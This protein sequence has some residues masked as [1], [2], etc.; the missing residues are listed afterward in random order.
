VRP[1]LA[2]RREASV[3]GAIQTENNYNKKMHSISPLVELHFLFQ[4]LQQIA[5][6]LYMVLQRSGSFMTLLGFRAS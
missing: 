1:F 3:G 6:P 2:E 5:Q 4:I